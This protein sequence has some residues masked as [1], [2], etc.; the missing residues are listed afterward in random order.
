M[1]QNWA[2]SFITQKDSQLSFWTWIRILAEIHD[3]SILQSRQN[4]ALTPSEA[5]QKWLLQTSLSILT[6]GAEKPNVLKWILKSSK[7]HRKKLKLHETP[8]DVVDCSAIVPKL[9]EQIDPLQRHPA[10]DTEANAVTVTRC[11]TVPPNCVPSWSRS[12][13]TFRNQQ[14]YNGPLMTH[15]ETDTMGV[16]VSEEYWWL[17]IHLFPLS[18]NL[19]QKFVSTKLRKFDG[20]RDAAMTLHWE[21]FAIREIFSGQHP[22]QWP[23]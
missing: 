2:I 18:L 15:A 6:K 23:C 8:Q 9:P 17:T 5:T 11:D 3:N 13:S 1:W 7:C 10:R 4:M 19:L 14:T 16:L 22:L 12:V 21:G 20:F